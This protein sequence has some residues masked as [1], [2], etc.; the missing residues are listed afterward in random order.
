MLMLPQASSLVAIVLSCRTGLSSLLR[1]EGCLGVV[2]A[3]VAD[4]RHSK[5]GV[6]DSGKWGIKLRFSLV[7]IYLKPPIATASVAACGH[8]AKLCERIAC[9]EPK[10]G[11]QARTL[12]AAWNQDSGQR[13]STVQ[14]GN[15]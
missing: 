6:S 2:S 3:V 12:T 4:Y 11:P 10:C 5:S 1:S 14:Q 8:H 15:T 7:L 13:G 9:C